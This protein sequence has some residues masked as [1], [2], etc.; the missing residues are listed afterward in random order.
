MLNTTS[1]TTVI[2][3]TTTTIIPSTSIQYLN[4]IEFFFAKRREKRLNGKNVVSRSLGWLAREE[5]DDNDECDESVY[6]T[7]RDTRSRYEL[8]T[9]IATVAASALLY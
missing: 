5:D 9:F 8:S 7:S 6:A 1:H 2:A 3:T 4:N